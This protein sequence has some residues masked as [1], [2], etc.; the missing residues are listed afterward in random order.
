MT[1]FDVMFYVLAA[2]I[3]LSAAIMVFAKNLIYNAVGLL[4]AFFGVAGLYVMLGADFLAATQLLIYVGGILVL[5]LF[6]VMLSQ[7]ITGLEMRT[8]TLQML[9]AVIVC[10]GVVAIL[11]RMIWMSPWQKTE[12]G[13]PAATTRTIGTLFMTDYLIPFEIVSV[14]LLAAL[15]GAAFIGR[16]DAR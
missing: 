10:A 16:R 12:V 11:L 9:P 3:L 14:L 1:F 4:F 5:L 2:M 6:G 7:R 15:V 13:E 8:G